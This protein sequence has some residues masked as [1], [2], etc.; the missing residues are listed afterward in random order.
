VAEWDGRGLPP[1][2]QA[3]VDRYSSSGLRTSL[4]SVPG[5]V[6]AEVAGFTPIGEVMGCIVERIGLY[7]TVGM[8]FGMSFGDQLRPYREALRHGYATALNRLRMEAKGIGADGV[9]GVSLSV[10]DVGE[11]MREFVALGSAVRA[12]TRQRPRKL[13]TTELA[14]QDVGKLMQAGWVPVTIAIGIEAAATYNYYAQQQTSVWAGNTEVDD[15]THLVTA[16]RTAA[17]KEFHRQVEASGADGAIVSRMTLAM[18][19]LGEVAVMSVAT[20]FGTA[21]SQFHKGQTAPTSALTML[22]LNKR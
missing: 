17:R 7:S 19:P 22:P 20:V 3:R 14:G 16:A 5:A 12:E 10:T 6:G 2:A 1:V 13:F 21:I 9:V 15:Y 4:L 8:S 11:N 18:W